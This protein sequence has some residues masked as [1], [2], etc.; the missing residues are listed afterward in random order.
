MD[1]LCLLE[2]YISLTLTVYSELALDLLLSLINF[3][4]SFSLHTESYDCANGSLLFAVVEE[5][6]TCNND[7]TAHFLYNNESGNGSGNV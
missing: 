1:I 3:S 4:L 6:S 2:I 7:S 5:N